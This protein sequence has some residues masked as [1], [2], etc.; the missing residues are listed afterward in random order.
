MCFMPLCVVF[1]WDSEEARQWEHRTGSLVPWT[2]MVA[3]QR[4]VLEDS[5]VC[6]GEA[7]CSEKQHK[8]LG[9][10]FSCVCL[11][12]AQSRTDRLGAGE[13]AQRVLKSTSYKR[14]PGFHSQH[15]HGG[16]HSSGTPFQ[17]PNGLFW[18]PRAPGMH[19]AHRHIC[20]QTTHTHK[21]KLSLLGSSP[22]T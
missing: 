13:L 12:R 22:S 1:P 6:G 18:S 3:S 2:G 19:M 14:E 20:R 17:G 21:V 11:F 10:A 9:V 4:I 16:S 8:A 5:D 15:P 7:H